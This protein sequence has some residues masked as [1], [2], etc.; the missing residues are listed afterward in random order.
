[1][2]IIKNG[3]Y[4]NL[5]LTETELVWK[6]FLGRN[7]DVSKVAAFPNTSGRYVE[8]SNKMIQRE[9][10]P[11]KEKNNTYLSVLRPRGIRVKIP[12]FFTYYYGSDLMAI[13]HLLVILEKIVFIQKC[14]AFN[15]LDDGCTRCMYLYFSP[16]FALFFLLLIAFFVFNFQLI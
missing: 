7:S 15:I 3:N 1:M 2:K 12:F 4:Y 6:R 8:N 9:E 11:R 10:K 13:T 16:Q 5:F 14:V